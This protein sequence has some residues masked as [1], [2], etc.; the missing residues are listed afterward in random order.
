MW[1]WMFVASFVFLWYRADKNVL[2]RESRVSYLVLVFSPTVNYR[3]I[4]S[5]FQDLESCQIGIVNFPFSFFFLPCCLKCW[6]IVTINYCYKYSFFIR[7]IV[8]Q[9][10]F[11]CTFTV[12]LLF[13]S[14]GTSVY[15]C[16]LAVQPQTDS[17]W[18]N[19]FLSVDK[20]V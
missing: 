7:L 19:Y 6:I 10:D 8:F 16:Q 1:N 14:E 18:P 13:V 15:L 11:I 4:K 20:N 9:F 12:V 17:H 5:T 2:F 3:R